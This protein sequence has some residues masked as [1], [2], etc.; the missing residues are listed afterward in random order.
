MLRTPKPVDMRARF[1]CGD[2]PP[3]SSLIMSC[4][5]ITVS[6]ASESYAARESSSPVVSSL[7]RNCTTRHVGCCAPEFRYIG[8]PSLTSGEAQSVGL[9]MLLARTVPARSPAHLPTSATKF[10]SSGPRGRNVPSLSRH[11]FAHRGGGAAAVAAGIGV[12]PFCQTVDPCRLRC[13]QWFGGEPGWLRFAESGRGAR[14]HAIR[15][16][17]RR[18]TR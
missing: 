8:L 13:N 1:A 14:V 10:F 2:A 11:T 4:T 6:V 16:L 12:P 15:I 7:H 9:S 17:P 3:S 18:Q 5:R